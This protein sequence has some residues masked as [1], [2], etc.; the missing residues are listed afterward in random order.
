MSY[1]TTYDGNVSRLI[2]V[3]AGS[4]QVTFSGTVLTESD[5]DE[6]DTLS[7]LGYLLKIESVDD[8]TT[9]TLKTPWPGGTPSPNSSSDWCIVR[10]SPERLDQVNAARALVDAYNFTTILRAR[11]NVFVCEYETATPPISP[12]PEE[13]AYYLVAA[14]PSGWGITVLQGDVVK[15]TSGQWGVFSPENGNGVILKGTREFKV[16]ENGTWTMAT[17]AAITD[18]ELLALA[19]VTSAANKL[20]YFTGS[21][22]GAVTDFTAAA[23]TVLDD[24]T[25][26]DMLTTLGLTA[27]GKSLVTAANYAAMRTLLTA[28]NT[29]GDTMTGGLGFGAGTGSGSDDLSR[30][31]NLHTSGY[32]FGVTSFRL[33]YVAPASAGHYWRVNAADVASVTSTGMAIT[34]AL[35]A[36]G[37]LLLNSSGL[38]A[39]TPPTGT[40]FHMLTGSNVR[41]TQDSFAGACQIVLRR[42]EGSMASPSALTANLVIGSIQ[43]WGYGASA[44]SAAA[45]AQLQFRS[46][47]AWTATA[48]G[49]DVLIQTTTPG[50]TTS[51]TRTQITDIS[52][53]QTGALIASTF[54]KPGSY[55]V[56]TVPSASTAGAGA[57][58]YV[59]N[60]SGGAVL[61]FSDGSNW[62]RVTD[63]ATIS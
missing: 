14:S 17:S 39:P 53:A 61:A 5:I 24:A 37:E 11:A 36:T 12:A 7:Y 19:A 33:N 40:T 29:A 52:L 50:T 63:L 60:E 32:G 2:S 6:L 49:T 27:N 9:I 35:S 30:H 58:I 38:A 20:F 48:Q 44:Y 13:G 3:T 45:R 22:T 8:D 1:G 55:T 43:S 57:T 62:K 47:E 54:V 31:I 41:Q 15:Y 46:A 56:A 26:S 16:F 51:V 42:A 23:R 21:G 34:G 18:P 4:D 59:S 25:V 28:L 10:E